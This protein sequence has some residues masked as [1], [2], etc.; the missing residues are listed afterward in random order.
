MEPKRL[1]DVRMPFSGL[2][3]LRKG[4][5]KEARRK[6]QYARNKALFVEQILEYISNPDNKPLRYK[7]DY[8]KILSIP[9]VKSLNGYFSTEEFADI[10]KKGL[11]I[12]RSRY[13]RKLAAIDDGLIKKAKKGNAP[14][15]KLAYQRFEGW[16]ERTVT[17]VHNTTE[18]RL[19][20]EIMALLQPVKYKGVIDVESS[21]T[22]GVLPETI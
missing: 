9:S 21:G 22:S 18:V 17:E 2:G 6:G 14:E 1:R 20:A 5:V 3:E 8:M 7:K 13:A 11:E 12:R 19:D 4:A 10:E 15:V 16:S